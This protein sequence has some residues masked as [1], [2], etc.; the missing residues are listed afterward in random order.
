MQ[1]RELLELAAKA[2]GIGLVWS[3]EQESPR[4]AGCWNIWNPLR[5]DGDRYRLA[6]ACGLCVNFANNTVTAFRDG[7]QI[8]LFYFGHASYRDG[9]E[10]Y[11]IV[12]AAAE[13][14]KGM[15]AEG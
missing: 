6:K 8:A 13:I 4:D 3:S 10:G 7:A 2:A 14:G 9:D 11:C 12:R 1:D 15:S 5:D